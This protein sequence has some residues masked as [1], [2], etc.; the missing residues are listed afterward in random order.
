MFTRDVDDHIVKTLLRVVADSSSNQR[1]M[2]L[3]DWKHLLLYPWLR[4][5]SPEL[6]E[7]VTPCSDVFLPEGGKA[8]LN[9]ALQ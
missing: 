9:I 3:P 1:Q 6:R 4:P 2:L 8:S 7:N 5:Y